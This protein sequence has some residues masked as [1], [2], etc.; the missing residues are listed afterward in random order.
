MIS[1]EEDVIHEYVEEQTF[2]KLFSFCL[3][4]I[5][6]IFSLIFFW[7]SLEKAFLKTWKHPSLVLKIHN[8]LP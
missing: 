1:E 5:N 2:H 6:K 7:L 4:F 8:T 3:P